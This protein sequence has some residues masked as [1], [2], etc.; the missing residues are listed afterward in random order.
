MN[1][2][3]ITFLANRVWLSKESVSTPKPILKTIPD[4]FRKADR[5][6]KSPIDDSFVLGPDNGKIPT[7]KACPA[8]LIFI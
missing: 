7:W 3:K 5:F 8:I 2:E 4:W 1:T 6:F